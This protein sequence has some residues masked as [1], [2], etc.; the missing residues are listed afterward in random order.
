MQS[1][2][3]TFKEEGQY[4]ASGLKLI[5][6][7]LID[8]VVT[9]KEAVASNLSS[10]HEVVSLWSFVTVEYEDH[11]CDT[12]FITP[13][14]GGE[15]VSHDITA[16]RPISPVGKALYG[17]EEGASVKIVEGSVTAKKPEVKKGEIVEID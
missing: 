4:L 12:Y 8:A 6:M 1:R 15:K 16:V 17:K 5:E 11:G 2:Y 7:E 13:V 10:D 3:D 9:L 14:M